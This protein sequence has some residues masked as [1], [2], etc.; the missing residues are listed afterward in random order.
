[1]LHR[2]QM[3]AITL[4]VMLAGGGL[5]LFYNWLLPYMGWVHTLPEI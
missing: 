3:W 5:F 4:L 2:K 1:M